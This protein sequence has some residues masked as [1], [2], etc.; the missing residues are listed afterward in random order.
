VF[1]VALSLSSIRWRRGPGRGGT[2]AITDFQFSFINRFCS[3][4]VQPSN[5]K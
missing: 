1:S 4:L 2:V 3:A 5:L